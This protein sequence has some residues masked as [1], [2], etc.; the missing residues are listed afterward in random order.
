MFV[1]TLVFPGV[2][3]VLLLTR[4]RPLFFPGVPISNLP[5]LIQAVKDDTLR[6]GIIGPCVSLTHLLYP[7]DD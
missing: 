4:L 5:K 1:S 7:C 2:P 3:S 6:E